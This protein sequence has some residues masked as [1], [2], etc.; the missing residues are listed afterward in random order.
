[1]PNIEVI[2]R[3]RSSLNSL[4]SRNHRAGREAITSGRLH[5]DR[6]EVIQP[7]MAI[8]IG[9]SAMC[10]V[11]FAPTAYAF[12][13]WNVNGT[14][15]V[16]D[17][18]SIQNNLYIGTGGTVKFASGKL[19]DIV[20][21]CPVSFNLGFTPAL[22]G[23]TYYDDTSAAG[24]HVTVM[25]I[26]MAMDTGLISRIVTVDSNRGPVSSNGNANLVGQ[27]FTDN[28]DPTNFAYYLRI[29]VLR[30]STTAN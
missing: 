13:E 25:F 17:A 12:S 15:C 16:A 28:Y 29:D 19:G 27:E 23:L 11:C 2:A 10:A 21:Y 22:L 26:K 7:M 5:P 24:N 1:M 8:A 20:L 4:R 18:G 14:S 30:N 6:D 3:I 9:I